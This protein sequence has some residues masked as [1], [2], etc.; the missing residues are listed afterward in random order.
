VFVA[1]CLAIRGTLAAPMLWLWIADRVKRRTMDPFSKRRELEDTA[2]VTGKRA[3][4]RPG[5]N[6]P[7]YEKPRLMDSILTRNLGHGSGTRKPL[8]ASTAD[9]IIGTDKTS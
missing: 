3:K 8:K 6:P 9:Q 7:P 5:A 4:V 1:L 2:A